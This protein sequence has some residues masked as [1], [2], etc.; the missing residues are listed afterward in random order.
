M[1]RKNHPDIDWFYEKPDRASTLKTET[2]MSSEDIR[3]WCLKNG[4]DDVG[5]VEID[6]AVLGSQKEGIFEAFPMTSVVFYKLVLY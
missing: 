5:F 6:R 2:R 4:A 1:N 3:D